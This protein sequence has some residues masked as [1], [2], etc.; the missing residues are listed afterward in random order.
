L[1]ANI[2]MDEKKSTQQ[3]DGAGIVSTSTTYKD[4]PDYF[5]EAMEDAERLLK[6]ASETGLAVDDV[7]RDAVLEARARLE[8]GWDQA[9]A[10]QLLKALSALALLT[11]PVSAASL[12]AYFDKTVHTVR[13]YGKMAAWLAVFIVPFSVAS[14]VAYTLSA[15]INSDVST[16]N[17]LAVKLRVQFPPTATARF[18]DLDCFSDGPLT[19][20]AAALPPP[21]IRPDDVV[22]ELQQYAATIR[23]IHEH[24]LQLRS[25][26]SSPLKIHSSKCDE[27]ALPCIGLLN[28]RSQYRI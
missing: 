21:R 22:L 19:S 26:S 20:A 3:E 11:K 7:M 9:I 2:D 17:S 28:Y 6:Y 8:S 14:F 27:I 16:A 24:N 1:P 4:P 12:V 23:S 15:S 5:T 25:F 10:A 13:G 18:T